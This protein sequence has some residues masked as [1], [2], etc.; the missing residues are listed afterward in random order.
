MQ[1]IILEKLILLMQIYIMIVALKGLSLGSEFSFYYLF[2]YGK[3]YTTWYRKRQ[4]FREYLKL[5]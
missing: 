1:W 2:K 4:T 3:L 5:K